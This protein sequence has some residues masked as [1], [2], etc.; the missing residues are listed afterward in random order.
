M[1]NKKYYFTKKKF[2]IFGIILLILLISL[3]F[4]NKIEKLINEKLL[5]NTKNEIYTD[6]LEVH[7]INVGQGDSIVIK[8]PDNKNLLI[9][10]GPGSNSNDLITYLQNV[11]FK[12]KANKNIDYFILTHSDEDHIGGAPL[13]FSTFEILNVYR[14]QI[15]TKEESDALGGGVKVKD[16]KI[17]KSTIQA[18]NDEGSNVIYNEA[19]NI[20]SST[21]SDVSFS[22]EFL[23]PL[24]DDYTD[25][26]NFSPL[27]LLTF[28]DTKFMFTG[29]AETE[30]ENEVLEKYSKEKLD[31]DILKV[32]HHGSNT[33]S[34]INF[35]KTLTPTIS[36]IEVGKD[37][38]YG[39]PTE[40]TLTSL[41]EVGSKIYRTDINNNIVISVSLSGNLGVMIDNQE[42][43]YVKYYYV[44][45]S[46]TV[47]IF[48]FIFTIP[49]KKSKNNKKG[50]DVE[51][52]KKS[53]SNKNFKSNNKKVKKNINKIIK[54]LN[55]N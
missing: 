26:N 55:S 13:V 31:I 52:N 37:N 38:K 34:S 12:D 17:Y 36:V 41:K 50:N 32:G 2:I 8:L 24:S 15:F 43:F 27:I 14:P 9:D 6:G 25:V 54:D 40:K 49:V 19:G 29:D 46:L 45:I 16:T 33:S 7:F 20:I 47:V 11:Y 48:V 51:N 21:K 4:S 5:N 18:I 3:I 28:K 39:H 53:N 10:A 30:V 22:L 23:S 35:L 44:V 1:S 42:I